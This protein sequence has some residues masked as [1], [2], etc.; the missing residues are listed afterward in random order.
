M[1][2]KDPRNDM[3]IRKPAFGQYNMNASPVLGSKD[4]AA[5][6]QKFFTPHLHN[7]KVQNENLNAF[8]EMKY[9]NKKLLNKDVKGGTWTPDNVG[10]P[11]NNATKE[12]NEFLNKAEEEPAMART[13]VK[14]ATTKKTD[15]GS[16]ERHENKKLMKIQ[17]LFKTE[18]FE[19]VSMQHVLQSWT[20]LTS[21]YEYITNSRNPINVISAFIRNFHPASHVGFMDVF[22]DYNHI[23]QKVRNFYFLKTWACALFVYINDLSKGNF[24]LKM[25]TWFE[26]IFNQLLQSVFYMSLIISKAL[27]NNFIKNDQHNVE[28][29]SKYLQKYNFPTGIPLIKTLK[30]NNENVFLSLKNVIGTLDVSLSMYFEKSNLK[31]LDCLNSC[32]KNVLS[33][34]GPLMSQK[35]QSS[36]HALVSNLTYKTVEDAKPAPVPSV[37]SVQMFTDSTASKRYTLVFDLDETLIHFKTENSK[38][39]FLIRPHAYNILRNL[40][41]HFEIIIFTAAQKEYADFILNLIDTQSAISHRFYREHCLMAQNCH[42]K[43]G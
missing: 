16:G 3:S 41:P 17:A 4:Q 36:F 33:F 8:I 23:K 38:S 31:D 18:G 21:V 26:A 20:E 32:F 27:R 39:K 15:H 7:K 40:Q 10:N 9:Q 19:K 5:Q 43:V 35:Y 30:T 6:S 1:Y 12:N 29:F 42:I 34:L 2:I 37:E 14:T 13:L 25:F 22:T 11:A 24:D 28:S